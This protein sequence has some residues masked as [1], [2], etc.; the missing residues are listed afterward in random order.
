MAE[1]LF[2]LLIVLGIITVVGHA[3]WW[4][5]AAILRAFFGSTPQPVKLTSLKK[6]CV[7]CGEALSLNDEFCANCGRSQKPVS[8]PDPLIDLAMTARQ[9]DRF[10]NLGKIDVATHQAVMN[11]IEEER[12]RLTRPMRSQPQAKPVVET[13][14][15]VVVVSP[16][17]APPPVPAP[18][19]SVRTETEIPASSTPKPIVVP[20]K[21]VAPPEPP[22]E[23]RRS[24]A[25]M[26]ETFMEESSI[27]WG[28]IIG[29][30]LIIGCSLAL[31]ISLWAQITAVPL[32]KFSVFVGVT[33]GLFGIGFYSAHRWKLPTTSRGA[34]TIST[35]LVP[36]NFLA[37]TAF[38][39]TAETN[40]PLI[41]AGEMIALM[42]FLFLV[43]QAG[44]VITP[45]RSLVSNP[46][47]LSGVTLLPSMAMLMAKHW[48]S[49][50]AA[51]MWLGVAPM[52]CYW[53]GTGAALRGARAKTD[54]TD[55]DNANRVFLILG[56]ASFA[57]LLPCSLF[58]AKAGVFSISLHRFA[59]FITLFAVPAIAVGMTFRHSATASGKTKTIATSIALLGAMLAMSGLALTWP[60][61]LPMIGTALINCVVCIVLARSF[62]LKLAQIGAL[63]FFALAYLIG[64]N[65][66]IGDLPYWN[67][68]P[69]RLVA[70][71]WSRASGLTWMS[72]FVLFA[73]IAEVF[74][75]W[76]RKPEAR[77]QE[78]ASVAAALFSLLILIWHGFGLAGDPQ[79]LTLALL[80]FAASAFFI[81]WFRDQFV[82]SWIGW[83][84]ALLAVVQ[85]F[86]FKFGYQL[87]PYHPV[88]LSLLT[89]ASLATVVAVVWRNSGGK[90]RRNVTAP[91]TFAALGCS[92]AVAPFVMFGGWMS[93]TQ[94][95]GRVFWLAAIWLALSLLNGWR[96]LFTAFQAALTV[97]VVCGVLAIFDAQALPSALVWQHLLRWQ[98]IGIA[99]VWLSIAWIAL[100][101]MVRRNDDTEKPSNLARLL[102]PPWPTVDRI[103]TAA[104]WMM[105]LVLSL[106]S[107]AN[108]AGSWLL[109]MSLFVVFAVGL[110]EQ[111]Q[112]RLVMAMMTLLASGCLLLSWRFSATEISTQWLRWSA[113][114]SFALVT[115]PILFREPL[116]Q[117]CLRFNW[118][119]METRSAGLARL[120]RWESL[121]LFAA[122]VL[123]LT[124]MEFW[125]K[126]LNASNSLASTVIFLTPILI[127]SLSL[128]AHAIRENS[129][130]YTLASGLLLNLATT[131]GCLL[132][133]GIHWVAIVQ[134]NIITS[135]LFA[136]VWLTARTR[137][138]WSKAD[139]EPIA[140]PGMILQ[141]QIAVTMIASMALLA[142]AAALIAVDPEI[143]SRM[144]TAIGN[145]WGWLATC[146]SAAAWLSLRKQQF[147]SRLAKLKVEQ[148][149]VAVLATAVLVV[150]SLSRIAG[151]WASYRALLIGIG[152]SAWLM[153]VVRRFEFRQ[154][155][156]ENREAAT[157]WALAL[158]LAQLAMTWRGM[159]A[160]DSL[161]WTVGS[162]AA[163]S[164]LFGWMAVA[165]RRRSLVY[166]SA[167]LWNLILWT[168]FVRRTDLL[169][170]VFEFVALNIVVL[171]LTSLVW[172]WLDLKTMRPAIGRRPFHR[173]TILLTLPTLL[174]TSGFHW[175]IG[176]VWQDH[177]EPLWLIWLAILSVMALLVAY[178]WDE[179]VTASL[180]GLHLTGV[181]VVLEVCSLLPIS[182][183][184]F[185]AV[186]VAAFSMYALFASWL[187]R[188]REL[189]VQ[190]AERTGIVANAEVAGLLR[191]WLLSWHSLF[192]A[193]SFLFV[194]F[195]LFDAPS[196]WNRLLATSGLFALP[197]AFALLARGERDQ[198]LITASVRLCL[199]NLVMWSWAWLSPPTVA[200]SWQLTNRLIIVM[201]IAEAVLIVYRLILT[202]RLKAENLWR[203]ALRADLP[204]VAGIGL[205]GL[206]FV[207]VT[208]FEQRTNFGVVLL[209]WPAIVAVLVT[210]IGVSL[211]GIA[212]AVLP[213]EDPFDLDERGKMRYVY[214][215][216]VFLV[217][218]FVHLRLTMP[219]LFGGIFT[220][221]WPIAVMLLAFAGVALSEVFRRQGKLVLAE[222]LAKTGVLL[223][224]LPVIGF[225]SLNSQVPYSGLLLTVGLFYGVLSVMKRSLGL[226][227]L[228]A[229]A[230]NSGLWHFLN[231][232]EGLTFFE[233]PQ[234]WLIPM[235]V[236]VLLA[237]RI[238]RESL[239]AEQMNSIRYGA[240]VTI[241]VSSTADIFIN[242]VE[243]APWLPI[244]LAVLAVGGVI[245][246]LMMRIRAFL[247]LGTAFLLLSMLTMI[248][249][250]SVNLQWTWLWYV[251][252]IAF[253]VLI[254]YTVAMFERKREQM[255]GFVERLKQWQ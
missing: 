81:A 196:L 71:L 26:L 219:W 251:T 216:E 28:E 10:L 84:L 140:A 16:I 250:A 23:P 229:L 14:P 179:N 130:T 220:A 119:Q 22:P 240:L 11:A 200:G 190:L 55:E 59:P 75:R 42:L 47:L 7:E 206:A 92:I 214:L 137:L 64:A 4:M 171:S 3:I 80:F 217:L 151:G 61:P 118:P 37:M 194:L 159:Q 244:I 67:E 241:Y 9:L 227:L 48:Q 245:A 247:F 27:R 239:S 189:L 109:L 96:I 142:L 58:L 100:R 77:I 89:L 74:R 199:V 231:R 45:G 135:A 191:N 150:C 158:G 212:F 54:E 88:R 113:A 60:R 126:R 91:A 20:V 51:M 173:M 210:L 165:L 86:A 34:L 70:C 223:P 166:L 249:S 248:W 128:A 180:R 208:E 19:L 175:G 197:I 232:V 213:G 178:L 132:Q 95:T 201:L 52:V 156:V 147:G 188:R 66:L 195:V 122:P 170:H 83:S 230:G 163:L 85:A 162:Y 8:K 31:V 131:L 157:G 153:F 25:E 207:L 112:R 43:Y 234:L 169:S 252:G 108:G 181:V 24:F 125:T 121:L 209:G 187:W 138:R 41:I 233:H 53:L 253:G 39:Q 237:A 203:K 127:L 243:T 2:Y 238:N 164:L 152:V 15:P 79:H 99:L 110:W 186:S 226:G 103:V 33:A 94:M 1:I 106:V 218:T 82:A 36:L 211:I 235:A 176:H 202:Q 65:V 242:G 172:L 236:S 90:I 225:W 46:W 215:T 148:L 183:H 101:L 17:V 120:A 114:V 12:E 69:A 198:G 134:A 144:I 133:P 193:G 57:T 224:L 76:A 161:W 168:L 72:L 107:G 6:E 149:G 160:P 205:V 50:Q 155:P 139:A 192:A 136:L 204:A 129:A 115:L 177:Q 104:V 97:A 32:L 167:P 255:I 123:G 21:P 68:E 63:A 35:L 30:L 116:R 254:I 141:T 143:L 18:V 56:I 182:E 44:K 221:Y 228:A 73:A 38:S 117:F 111:F 29:G 246:G 146:L 174:L 5:I 105:S 184:L 98:A 185:W 222:P 78:V 62:D 145:G 102:F 40:S 87:A 154:M 93:V 124:L 49:R 13:P